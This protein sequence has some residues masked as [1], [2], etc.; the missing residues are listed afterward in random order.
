MTKEEAETRV[1][2]AI[3]MDFPDIRGVDNPPGEIV[4][5]F[6]TGERVTL[7]VKEVHY[8]WR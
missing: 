6:W 5:E 4:V 2:E 3:A 8:K 1:A 7:E